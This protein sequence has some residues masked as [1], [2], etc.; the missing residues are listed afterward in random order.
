MIKEGTTAPDL[1]LKTDDGR[2]LKL[3][4]LRGK[5]VVLFFYPKDDTR[6]CTIQTCGVRDSYEAL[7]EHGAEIFGI[8]ISDVEAHKAFR[9]KFSLPY[10]LLVD[11]DNRLADAF[12]IDR[13][14]YKGEEMYKRQS[15]VIDA[16]GKVAKVME[17]VD[18]ETHAAELLAVLPQV[19]ENPLFGG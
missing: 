1:D 7:R 18:P 9:D 17:D 5:P 6:G 8:S 15:V 2:E 12:G 4:D 10:P 13:I 14:E 16:D 19:S 11:E 3:S